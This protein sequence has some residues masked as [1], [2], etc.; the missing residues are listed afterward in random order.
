MATQAKT[1]AFHTLGCKLNFSE[2]S[3]ISRNFIDQGFIK[4]D[5]RDVADIYVLNTCSVTDNADKEA[6]KLIRQAKRRNPNSF[7]AVMGCYAQLKPDEISKMEGVDIVVGAENK[8]EILDYLDKVELQR[9]CSVYTSDIKKTTDFNPSYSLGERT[10]SYLKVQDGCDYTC[11]FCTIPL[12][13]GK[14]RS[15]KIN[16][17]IQM[18]K[19]IALSGK[20]EIVL[21]GVNI[22]DYGKGTR[23][24]FLGLIKEL[25]KINGIK[26]I[27]IS[28]IEPNLLSDEIIDFCNSSKLFMPHFHIP[29]QSGSNKILRLMRRRYDTELYSS[30]V[31]YIKSINQNVCIG[32]D[33]IV[34]FPGESDEDFLDTYNFIKNI[35]ISYLHVFTYS[36]RTGTDALGF[37][38]SVSKQKRSERSKILRGLSNEKKRSFYEQ[39]VSTNRDVL[40]ETIKN[41]VLSGYTDN[42]IQVKVESHPN[43]MNTI[44]P[45][46]LVNIDGSDV[47]G[48]LLG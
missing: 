10:R 20:K 42:Y 34:G 22:G 2:T 4:V 31:N 30:R 14:S 32:A 26:R 25:D 19:E 7:V 48:K 8:F 5:Y 23:E 27:R 21:T 35:D 12:A 6:R 44:Y 18:A 17:I 9:D 45:T 33:V 29:L 13:R 40:F 16:R 28:S 46:S 37:G 36:E 24:S 47:R 15:D 38:N 39:H 1:I 43:F 3:T 11:S 41:G